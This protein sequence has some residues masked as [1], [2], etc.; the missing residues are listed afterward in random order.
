MTTTL[1][2]SLFSLPRTM[3]SMAS[4][5]LLFGFLS[6]VSKRTQVPTVNL[7]I[8]GVMS[9]IIALFF[10]LEHLIEF[11]S[12]GTFLAY[13]IVSASV[14]VLRYRPPPPPSHAMDNTITT[15]TTLAST[16]TQHLASPSN[17]DL[18]LDM[19]DCISVCTSVDTQVDILFFFKVLR[20]E[21]I[22]IE[23]LLQL[24]QGFCIESIGRVKPK[25]VYLVNLLGDCKP[26]TAVATAII[27]YF[28][29]CIA[30]CALMVVTTQEDYSLAWYDYV[31]ILN[32]FMII[33]ASEFLFFL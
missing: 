23:F 18:G 26:G 22:M 3:Y 13:T 16:S 4:D 29:G 1:F 24:I 14:I 17:T 15:D 25:H 28:L 11:M 9:G 31:L 19:S 33:G 8:S 2:G 7:A 6:K 27:F 12:I 10:D 20:V 21:M 5:G 32:V 30:F